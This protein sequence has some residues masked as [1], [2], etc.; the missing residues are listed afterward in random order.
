[1]NDKSFDFLLESIDEMKQHINGT[2]KLKTTTYEIIEV[3]EIFPER[4]KILR[5]HMGMTQ[6][7]FGKFMGVS[8][9]AVESWEGGVTKPNGPARRLMSILEDDKLA[10]EMTEKFIVKC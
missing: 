1:M 2:V 10:S 8:T 3:P 7:V 9:R 5:G 4:I 6:K